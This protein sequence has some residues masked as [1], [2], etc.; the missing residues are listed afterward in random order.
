ML[1]PL[2]WGSGL[3][4]L[5]LKFGTDEWA[6]MW[7]ADIRPHRG[8]SLG[9]HR[10]WG[11]PSTIGLLAPPGSSKREP[12]VQQGLGG[13][14]PGPCVPTSA[15]HLPASSLRSGTLIP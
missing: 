7:A 2:V 3:C 14:A 8:A 9:R 13:A 15:Q 12:G 1:R 10:T 11:R 6:E 4:H 5:C